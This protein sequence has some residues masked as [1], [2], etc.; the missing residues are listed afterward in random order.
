MNDAAARYQN[1]MIKYSTYLKTSAKEEETHIRERAKQDRKAEEEIRKAEEESRKNEEK[2]R[3]AAEE[4]KRHKESQE[5]FNGEKAELETAI[6]AFS[7]MTVKVQESL[8]ADTIS[9][10]DKRSEWR[11]IDSEF[12]SLKSNLIRLTGL[13]GDQDI[14]QTNSKF[15]AA[16]GAYAVMQKWVFSQVK[17]I[18]APLSSVASS[19]VK[20]STT[21]KESVQLPKFSGCEKGS[22][23][24]AYPT[25]R[26]QW[27]KLIRD[28]ENVRHCISI[29]E[30]INILFA[31][32]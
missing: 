3:I 6:D 32:W 5:K 2:E 25:W 23:F 22:P 19:T 28:I 8:S 10:L 24:L 11:K 18:S 13:A 12:S 14:T 16:E 21:K 17:D 26:K 29:K 30:D 15:E 4:A 20:S 27:D 9:D 7:R 31:R 1:V